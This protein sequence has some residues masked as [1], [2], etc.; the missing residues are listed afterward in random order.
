MPLIPEGLTRTAH[1]SWP[2]PGGVASWST[3]ISAPSSAD[4][5][6]I[7]LSSTW[8][9]GS[10]RSSAMLLS[11]QTIRSG[12][13][14]SSVPPRLRS[15]VSACDACERRLASRTTPGCTIAIVTYRTAGLAGVSA[16]ASGPAPRLA[17]PAA[18]PRTANP[19]RREAPGRTAAPIRGRDSSTMT[20]ATFASTSAKLTSQTP[21]TEARAS[22]AGCCHWLTPNTA[23]GP[24]NPCQDRSHS[25]NSQQLGTTIMAASALGQL[26]GGRSRFCAATPNGIHSTPNTAAT[27]STAGPISGAIQYSAAIRYPAPSHQARTPPSRAV[28][29]LAMSTSPGTSPNQARN[30]KLTSGKART[31]S[32]PHSSINPRT[33]QIHLTGFTSAL[34]SPTLLL[35]AGP[36]ARRDTRVLLVC[37]GYAGQVAASA[38]TASVVSPARLG[39]TRLARASA[40]GSGGYCGCGIA[41]T[42]RPAAAA[43]RSPLEESSTAAQSG[44]GQP[45]PAVTAR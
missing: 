18:T 39:S 40:S 2:F 16:N 5:A 29:D 42:R 23:H 30:S 28:G 15:A 11:P 6:S 1:F 24:P 25:V 44:G 7:W 3:R 32:A 34:R 8:E 33:D 10:V 9:P 4:S 19:D 36:V 43:E 17:T 22:R 41:T 20:M 35:S 21:P 14:P 38:A 27:S 37:S 12:R 45:S 13:T 26:S 31:S